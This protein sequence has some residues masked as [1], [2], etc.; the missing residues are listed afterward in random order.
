MTNPLAKELEHHGVVVI[1]DLLA[2]AQLRRCSR[3]SRPA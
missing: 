1:S 3:L 2:P